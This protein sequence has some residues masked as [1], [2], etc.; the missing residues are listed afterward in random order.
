MIVFQPPLGATFTQQQAVPLSPSLVT[1]PSLI[2]D[3]NNDTIPDV[4][5]FR[6]SNSNT[7]RGRIEI[8]VGN[9][10]GTTSF[11]QAI[12]ESTNL[13]RI[14]GVDQGDMN[15]DGNLDLIIADGFTPGQLLILFG[16]GDGTF[17]TPSGSPDGI[18]WTRIS[19]PEDSNKVVVRDFN[20]DGFLDFFSGG[21]VDQGLVSYLGD[22]SGSFTLEQE[23]P[24]GKIASTMNAVDFNQ[25]GFVDI[26]IRSGDD[27]ISLFFGDGVGGFSAPLNSPIDVGL[28]DFQP[29]SGVVDLNQDGYPDLAVSARNDSAVVLFENNRAGGFLPAVTVPITGGTSFSTFLK[30]GDL[31][32]DSI[33]DLVF[34]NDVN[35]LLVV[36]GQGGGQY[37]EGVPIPVDA[38]SVGLT[39]AD[40]TQN[41]RNDLIISSRT[42]GGSSNAFRLSILANEATGSMEY[43]APAG[44]FST[45][46]ENPDATFTRR[47]KNGT[48]IQFDAQGLQTSLTDRNGNSTS[49]DYDAQDRLTTI[50]DPVGKSTILTYNGSQ[51]ESIIDPAGRTTNFEH[52]GEG[53]LTK[54]TDP[55]LSV[56]EFSYD[57]RHRLVFQKSKRDFITHYEYNFAGHSVKASRPDGSTREVS[58]S[59]WWAYSTRTVELGPQPIRLPLCGPLMRWPVLPMAKITRLRWAPT[60]LDGRRSERMP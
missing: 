24:Y 6:W 36:P 32:Q 25:D 3:F 55:D 8:H 37:G 48:T 18:T 4:A 30:A 26:L 45:L 52:D 7:L 29:R 51:L 54:I 9:G 16:Q 44:E 2:G 35:S 53:N 17:P 43:P 41:G 20:S 27:F 10:D 1:L 49:Y 28:V 23:I 15:S 38:I 47:L 40:F 39:L 34:F 11:L 50:T 13:L 46:T 60:G 21:A 5:L 33:D 59:T 14:G 12:E 57:S 42:S 19:L 31:N 58:R 22:G 56:R